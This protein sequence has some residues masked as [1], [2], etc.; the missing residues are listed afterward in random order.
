MIRVA[1]DIPTPCVG[2]TEAESLDAAIEALCAAGVDRGRLE[3]AMARRSVEDPP[4]ESLCSEF[5]FEPRHVHCH[6]RDECMGL[7]HEPCERLN[8]KAH[9]HH[10]CHEL[11]DAPSEPR[12]WR[13]PSPSAAMSCD[14]EPPLLHCAGCKSHGRKA[15]K[16]DDCEGV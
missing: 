2:A 7:E 13:W 1:F 14:Y 5:D 11:R 8:C 9:E 16:G 15:V 12:H 3:A 4:D 10:H 6:E